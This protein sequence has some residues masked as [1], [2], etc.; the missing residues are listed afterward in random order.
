MAE[1]PLLPPPAGPGEPVPE[2]NQADFADVSGHQ[3]GIDWKKYADSGRK[4]AITKATEGDNW[5]DATTAT[6]RHGM[7][8]NHLECGLYHFAGSTI[9]GKIASPKTEADYFLNTVGKLGPLE[10]PVLDFERSWG[11][12]PA[13]QVKWINQWMTIVHEKTG[14]TPWLYAPEYILKHLDGHQLTKWP[15]WIADYSSSDPQHPP[16]SDWPSLAAWQYTDRAR[17]PGVP[18]GTDDSWLYADPLHPSH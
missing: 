1:Q 18:G 12:S 9:Q 6:Y 10:F 3:K 13:K 16:S 17:I 11:M 14:K 5:S 8:Q 15:L 7:A 2:E 4:L